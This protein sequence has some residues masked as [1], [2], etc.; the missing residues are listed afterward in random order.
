MK[1]WVGYHRYTLRVKFVTA[2]Y[3]ADASYLRTKP[4]KVLKLASAAYLLVRLIV[5]KLRYMLV[6]P[7]TQ[8]TLDNRVSLNPHYSLLIDVQ[9][10]IITHFVP[11]DEYILYDVFKRH[12]R[13]TVNEW[14]QIFF[15]TQIWWYFQLTLI[16]ISLELDHII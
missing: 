11:W 16:M 9:L 15:V 7:Y 5:R 13:V 4:E 6:M 2:A 3:L 1:V 14:L 8:Q 10:Q 12:K